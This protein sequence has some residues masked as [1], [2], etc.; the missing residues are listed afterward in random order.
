MV[1]LS[2]FSFSSFFARSSQKTVRTENHCFSSFSF[3]FQAK[4]EREEK[5]R[6]REE[7]ERERERERKKEKTKEESF[8]RSSARAW[9]VGPLALLLLSGRDRCWLGT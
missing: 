7:R 8:A 1:Q 2:F 9:V 3:F 6:E 4:E 5:R